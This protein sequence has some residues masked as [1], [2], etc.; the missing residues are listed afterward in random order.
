MTEVVFLMGWMDGWSE[1][2]VVDGK[3]EE[4]RNRDVF[5]EIWDHFSGWF[6]EMWFSMVSG[7]L[8]EISKMEFY[9]QYSKFCNTMWFVGGWNQKKGAGVFGRVQ[10]WDKVPIPF[11][12]FACKYWSEQFFRY[13]SGIVDTWCWYHN[14][15][16]T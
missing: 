7:I 3:K 1:K 15:K 10:T 9:L 12:R 5:Q 14:G 6:W 4:P 13:H 16:Q 8:S 11:W 2:G